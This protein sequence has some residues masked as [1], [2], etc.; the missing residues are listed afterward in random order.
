[1]KGKDK[2]VDG[3]DDEEVGVDAPVLD[4]GGE[5]NENPRGVRM[6]TDSQIFDIS[7]TLLF[8]ERRKLY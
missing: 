5:E 8:R 3:Q 1:M 6:E 4:D 2:E 7:E